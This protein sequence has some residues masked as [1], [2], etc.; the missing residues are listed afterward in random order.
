[1]ASM[2]KEVAKRAGDMVVK[3]ASAEAWETT[4]KLR[5]QYLYTTMDAMPARVAEAAKEWS[6]LRSKIAMREV[7]AND[8]GAA[9]TRLGELYAFYILGRTIGG[10]SLPA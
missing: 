5:T 7:T 4:A 6:E 9:V 1:M 8:I 2:I 10:R 3:G